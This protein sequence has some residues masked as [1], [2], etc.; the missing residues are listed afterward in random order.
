MERIDI[1]AASTAAEFA[2]GRVLFE[3]YAASLHI[4]LCFQNFSTELESLS[5]MYGPPHG[6]LLIARAADHLTGC[7]G[8]RRFRDD[9]CEMK[10]LYV[11]PAFRRQ[12][13]GHR[14]AVDVARHARALGYRTMVLDTLASMTAAYALYVSMGF[15]RAEAYYPNPVSDVRYMALDLQGSETHGSP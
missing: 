8:V 15:Q 2:A 9:I 13:L 12:Q 7:V 10:R 5:S 3:E 1:V 4:D 6:A 11:R 14:L